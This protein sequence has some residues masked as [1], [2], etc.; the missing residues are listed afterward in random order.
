MLRVT[1]ML[2]LFLEKL[3]EVAA[4]FLTLLAARYLYEISTPEKDLRRLRAF[5][6][7]NPGWYRGLELHHQIRGWRL[8]RSAGL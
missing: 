6:W 2:L 5:F 8:L 3:I 4:A 7:Y 1:N